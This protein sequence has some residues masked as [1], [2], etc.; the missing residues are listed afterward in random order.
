VVRIPTKHGPYAPGGN[1]GKNPKTTDHTSPREKKRHRHRRQSN[2]GERVQKV[3]TRKEKSR[4][5]KG[6]ARAQ[7]KENE[8]KS[9]DA[10][11]TTFGRETK[12]EKVRKTE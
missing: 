1:R 9:R 2:E 8:K 4:P 5:H 10:P 12:H 6:V 7:Q 11:R 3:A